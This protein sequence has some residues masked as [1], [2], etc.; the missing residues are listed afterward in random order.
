MDA[1][2]LS[3]ATQRL[4]IYSTNEVLTKSNIENILIN[5]LYLLFCIISLSFIIFDILFVRYLL[6][7][8]KDSI[9]NIIKVLTFDKLK[10][11]KLV[12]RVL[13]YNLNKLK[14]D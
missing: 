8:Y 7:N 11:D 6:T 13:V 3:S 5:N 9:K 12:N 14:V 10:I 4:I 2:L 1:Q